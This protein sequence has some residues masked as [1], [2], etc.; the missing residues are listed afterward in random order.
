MKTASHIAQHV[1]TLAAELR[2]ED[3][4]YFEACKA[5]ECELSK[6]FHLVLLVNENAEAHKVEERAAELLGGECRD[7]SV[8]AFS[9]AAMYQMPRPLLLKMALTAGKCVFQK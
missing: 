5:P 7:I 6:P 1:A 9:Q 2:V 4:W 8:H 3:I